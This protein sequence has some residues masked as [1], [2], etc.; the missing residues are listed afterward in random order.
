M[1]V[2][3]QSSPRLRRDEVVPLYDALGW[4][5]YTKDPATLDAALANSTYI[6]TATDGE[7]VVGL[8]RCI[9]D[10]VSILYI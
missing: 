7:T 2:T 3:I 5:G 1:P 9:S 8:A 10:D 6:A 4:T